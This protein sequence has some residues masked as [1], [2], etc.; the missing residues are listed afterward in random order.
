MTLIKIAKRS[1]V[2]LPNSLCETLSLVPGS[3]LD[4][5]VTNSR[6]VLRKSIEGTSPDYKIRLRDRYQLTLPAAFCKEEWVSSSHMLEVELE[7]KTLC[8]TPKAVIEAPS[9]KKI[10]QAVST[11]IEGGRFQ[12]GGLADLARR[13]SR[14]KRRGH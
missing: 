6:L 8:L 4:G 1:Q 13:S 9:S 7:G 5:T 10:K 2:T 12:P 3:I 11:T 14:R